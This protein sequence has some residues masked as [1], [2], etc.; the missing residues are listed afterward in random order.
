MTE[1]VTVDRQTTQLS[2]PSVEDWLSEGRLA[3]FIVE[4]IDRVDR[5]ACLVGD[6]AHDQHA[7]VRTHGAAEADIRH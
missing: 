1:V 4:V 2:P 6:E 7:P 3:R 5:P